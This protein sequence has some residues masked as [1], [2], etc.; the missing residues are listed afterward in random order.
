MST[1]IED[2]TINYRYKKIF[3]NKKFINK[4]FIC[5]LTLYGLYTII[6]IHLDWFKDI[7]EL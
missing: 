2:I 5:M 3:I 6:F 4:L 1:S 7:L